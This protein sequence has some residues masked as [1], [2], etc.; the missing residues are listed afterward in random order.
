MIDRFIRNITV[1]LLCT[2]I[3]SSGFAQA[4][5]S[6]QPATATEKSGK[7]P[8]KILT[9]GKK[10]TVQCSRN[11][12]SVLVWTSNGNRIIEQNELNTSNYSFEAPVKEKILF[13]RIELENGKL[14]TEKIGM[15]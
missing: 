12:K 11:I 5:S 3:M 10:V 14:F 6:K 9:N 1:A 7:K 13:L 8:F 15:Q 4:N 2:I